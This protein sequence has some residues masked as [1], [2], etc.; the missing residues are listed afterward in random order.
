MEMG[1]AAKGSWELPLAPMIFHLGH[2]LDDVE[3][4]IW[5]QEQWLLAYACAL[6]H[7]AEAHDGRCW[8][9]WLPWPSIWLVVVTEAFME[10]MG[11][12]HPEAKVMD[13]WGVPPVPLPC[14][15]EGL[16]WAQVSKLINE[17][18]CRRP[19]SGSDSKASCQT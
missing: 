7:M 17:L 15:C 18:A 13:C 12:Q 3:D 10:E 16:E 1:Q 6:Q 5:T 19:L 2:F 9:N 4:H 11:V 14:Q 8:L